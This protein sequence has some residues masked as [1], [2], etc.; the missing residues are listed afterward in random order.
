MAPMLLGGQDAKGLVGGQSPKKLDRAWPLADCQLKRLGNDWL[1]TGTIE[2]GR[3]RQ[4]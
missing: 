2:A 3:K 4:V 1:V